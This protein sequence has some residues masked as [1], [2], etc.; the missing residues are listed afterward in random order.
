M[1]NLMSVYLNDE[2]YEQLKQIAEQEKKSP[3]VLVKGWI[4]KIL[5]KQKPDANKVI[6]I[7]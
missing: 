1:S 6:R 2:H 5:E 7:D 3:A 4:I